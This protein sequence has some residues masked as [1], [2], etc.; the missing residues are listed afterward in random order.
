R[1]ASPRVQAW[2]DVAGGLLF[3]L[4]QCALI[5]WLSWDYVLSSRAIRE[6]SNEVSGL[7]SG[8]LLKTLLPIMPTP[9]AVQGVAEILK[10]LLF[11][12]GRGGAHVGEKVEPL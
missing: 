3:L 11:A 8:Y 4:P 1:D 9:L 5:Y 12:T 7:P 10:S 2:M 6:K